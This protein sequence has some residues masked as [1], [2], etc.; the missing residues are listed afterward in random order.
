[1]QDKTGVA[2]PFYR[3]PVFVGA[4]GICIIHA[5]RAGSVF[6]AKNGIVHLPLLPDDAWS[7]GNQAIDIATAAVAYWIAHRRKKVVPGTPP[8]APIE[9][10]VETVKRLTGNG[11]PTDTQK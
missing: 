5:Y 11:T 1:M 8:P 3:S 9:P 6:L 10:V 7:I 2:I 4:V